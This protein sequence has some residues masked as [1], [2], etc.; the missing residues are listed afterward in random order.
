MANYN[1]F[2]PKIR[3][4]HDTHAILRTNMPKFSFKSVIRLGSFTEL[5]DT[6]TKG[7]DRIEL[8][9]V[10]AISISANKRLMKEKFNEAGVQTADWAYWNNSDLIEP[11]GNTKIIKLKDKFFPIVVKHIHGSRGKGN[12]LIHTQQELEAW[13][14]GKSLNNY[15]I[16]A[17]ANYP[18]EYRLHISETGCF[19]TCRKMLKEDTPKE[20]RWF[21]NDA[22]CVWVKEDNPLFDKPVNWDAIV[23]DCINA[24]NVIGADFLAFDVKIQSAKD[25]EGNIRENPAY[26]LLECNSAPSFGEITTEKYLQELPKLLQNKYDKLK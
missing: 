1:K 2:R 21:R 25:K 10:E 17:F 7:G 16:E 8:N 11:I 22:N 9:T 15:I 4:R 24:L 5:P 6:V 14:N 3:S 13:K 12:T 18:R 20:Q 19:Y 26:I 23:N